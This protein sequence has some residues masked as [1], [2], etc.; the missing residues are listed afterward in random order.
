MFELD[1]TKA[2]EFF[3]SS[4]N[5]DAKKVIER[6]QSHKPKEG[7]TTPFKGG[8]IMKKTDNGCYICNINK[9]IISDLYALATIWGKLTYE[10][11]ETISKAIAG[12]KNQLIIETAIDTIIELDKSLDELRLVTE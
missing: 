3:N 11:Q 4:K 10:M 8:E 9:N 5:N 6:Y 12:D 2:E 7:V 1:D